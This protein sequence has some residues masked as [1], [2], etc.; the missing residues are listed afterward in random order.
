MNGIGDP[1]FVFG[2]FLLAIS[3]VLV[4][5]GYKFFLA[6]IKFAIIAIPVAF[7]WIYNTPVVTHGW[8]VGPLERDQVAL[9]TGC[10]F[11]AGS[12]IV[13]GW[14][15]WRLRKKTRCGRVKI[16]TKYASLDMSTL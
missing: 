16:N 1:L 5:L 15:W 8:I 9:L 4:V 2:L 12:L 14:K 13:I 11:S 6:W 10:L 7:I 3:F